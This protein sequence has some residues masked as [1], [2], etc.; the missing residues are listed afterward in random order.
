MIL[1]RLETETQL[2]NN[3]YPIRLLTKYHMINRGVKNKNI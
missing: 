1:N 2:H 3:H